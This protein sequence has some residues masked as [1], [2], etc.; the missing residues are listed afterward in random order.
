MCSSDLACVAERAQRAMA[1]AHMVCGH[2]DGDAHGIAVGSDH[3]SRCCYRYSDS[4]L[5]RMA[6]REHMAYS[7]TTV[8][9]SG[10][11]ARELTN[12]C[13]SA[14]SLTGRA[15]NHHLPDGRDVRCL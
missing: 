4:V 9:R 2:R 5:A 13:K 1:K 7:P 8:G 3:T 15:I 12:F 6:A 11:T 14:L 10:A